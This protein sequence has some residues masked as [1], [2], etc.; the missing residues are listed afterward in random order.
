MSLH[1]TSSRLLKPCCVPGWALG[2]EMRGPAASAVLPLHVKTKGHAPPTAT[3]THS[4][5]QGSRSL[6][7]WS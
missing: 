6:P 2:V 4:W 1:V 3:F 7:P 5:L